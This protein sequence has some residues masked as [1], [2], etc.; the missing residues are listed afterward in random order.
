MSKEFISFEEWCIRNNYN[1][2][3]NLWDYELNTVIP[4]EVAYGTR[5]KILFQMS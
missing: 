1:D 4:S 2:W 5:K 3:I